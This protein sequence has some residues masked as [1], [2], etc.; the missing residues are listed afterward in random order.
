MNASLKMFEEA[1]QEK[2]SL[3]N[4]AQ[5]L[6]DISAMLG[7]ASKDLNK[8]R[9]S[10][11]RGSLSYDYKDLC[12]NKESKQ[13]LFGDDLPKDV[14]NMKLTNKIGKRY[15]PYA[16]SNYRTAKRGKGYSYRSD[17]DYQ[18]GNR[19]AGPYQ[20]NSFLGKGRGKLPGRNRSGYSSYSHRGNSG[21]GRHFSR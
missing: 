13:W 7:E 2:P 14:G 4:M 12:E 19:N 21:K 5:H 15:H 9:R 3:Q 20:P 8:K 16:S 6:V 18:Y 11:I 10:F 1:R 17:R